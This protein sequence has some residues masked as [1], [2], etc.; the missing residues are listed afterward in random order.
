MLP[1]GAR[2]CGLGVPHLRRFAPLILARASPLTLRCRI[3]GEWVRKDGAGLPQKW[4]DP[5]RKTDEFHRREVAAALLGKGDLAFVVRD[6]SG[7]CVR[8]PV[9]LRCARVG[10]RRCSSLAQ[11]LVPLLPPLEAPARAPASAG[12]LTCTL[13][14]A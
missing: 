5:R 11:R 4:V 14:L 13:G 1:V 2:R 12:F 9:G 10:Q 8:V 3:V 6:A 7:S